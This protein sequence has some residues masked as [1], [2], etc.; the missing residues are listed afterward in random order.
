MKLFFAVNFILGLWGI[1]NGAYTTPIVWALYIAHL[2]VCTTRLYCREGKTSR[3][4][5]SR[6]KL[7]LSFLRMPAIMIAVMI[8]IGWLWASVFGLEIT[9]ALCGVYVMVAFVL[10]T[11][12]IV[13]ERE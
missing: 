3:F 6:L 2:L 4:L 12:D 9:Y 1:Q 8:L 11:I 13:A 10:L 7:W 5:D